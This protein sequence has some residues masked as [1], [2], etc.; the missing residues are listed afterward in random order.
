MLIINADDFGL[1][2]EVNQAVVRAFER[3]LCSSCTIMPN[4]PGFLDACQLIRARDLRN[5]VGLHLTLTEGLPV[6]QRVRAFAVFCDRDGRFH[7]SRKH[8]VVRLS[9]AQKQ[10]LS[11]EIDGQIDRCRQQGIPITHLDSHSHVHEEWAIASLVIEAAHK[12]A[13]PR[14]RLCKTFGSGVSVAKRWYRGIVNSRLRKAGLA[15]TD[16][17]GWP[18]DYLHFL[19]RYG[20][21][22]KTVD[23]W[24]IMTHPALDGERL[25]DSWL[26]RPLE[27][28]IAAVPGYEEAVSYARRQYRRVAPQ[29][30]EQ[31]VALPESVGR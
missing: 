28:T 10:A 30:D 5:H 1:S 17:F 14:V 29:R 7:L 13:I 21:T 16:R 25:M 24:E 18:E 15:G 31:N 20:G 12:W 11:E 26:H 22:K 3:G 8:R 4:M 2:H 23:S 9:A 19:R 27:D 6:T